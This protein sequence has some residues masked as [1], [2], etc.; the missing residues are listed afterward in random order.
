MPRQQV[1]RTLQSTELRPRRA[2]FCFAV[3][4]IVTVML[5]AGLCCLGCCNS[6]PVLW[7]FMLALSFRGQLGAVM[8]APPFQL[9]RSAAR[10]LMAAI[11]EGCWVK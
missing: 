4:K 8:L 9:S 1:T 2:V 3:V 6:N 7:A 5:L 11:D 10:H